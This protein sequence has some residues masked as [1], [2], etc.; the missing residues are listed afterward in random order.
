[1]VRHMREIIQIF[2]TMLLSDKA[3]I[4]DSFPIPGVFLDIIIYYYLLIKIKAD[5]LTSERA[6]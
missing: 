2:Q 1:M 4:V 5:S 6:N 3:F